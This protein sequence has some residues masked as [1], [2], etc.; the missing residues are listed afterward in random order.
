MA[1]IFLDLDGTLTDPQLGITRSLSY[2]MEKWNNHC[3]TIK[4]LVGRRTITLGKF[5]AVGTC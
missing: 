5:P 3:L 1:A 2:A 4:N